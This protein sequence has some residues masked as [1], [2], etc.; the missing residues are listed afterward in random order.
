M[1]NIQQFQFKIFVT[2]TIVGPLI[3]CGGSNSSQDPA[4][5]DPAP[6]SRQEIECVSV[7]GVPTLNDA[8]QPPSSPTGEPKETSQSP[9]IGD[10]QGHCQ[11][12]LIGPASLA[13]ENA[14]RSWSHGE[15]S[16]LPSAP[17]GLSQKVICEQSGRIWN[18]DHCQGDMFPTSNAEPQPI[19]F[20]ARL[21]KDVTFVEEI[22][23][24]VP[25]PEL[26]MMAD[27][28][29]DC[30]I[31]DGLLPGCYDR[32]FSELYQD[33]TR[34]KVDSPQ[35]LNLA[36]VQFLLTHLSINS[37]KHLYYILKVSFVDSADKL[38][39]NTYIVKPKI[40][41]DHSNWK[42][43]ATGLS[44]AIEKK[45]LS[46]ESN[47]QAEILGFLVNDLGMDLVGT[48]SPMD[49]WNEKEF[50]RLYT[51][52]K[53]PRGFYHWSKK[54]SASSISNRGSIIQF[55]NQKIWGHLANTKGVYQDLLLDVALENAKDLEDRSYFI[56]GLRD[57]YANS[58]DNDQKNKLSLAY[59][60]IVPVNNVDEDILKTAKDYVIPGQLKISSLWLGYGLQVLEKFGSRF[61]KSSEF[62][63]L[64]NHY[65]F[66]VRSHLARALKTFTDPLADQ[67]LLSLSVDRYFSVR[68]QALES[69]RSRAIDVKDFDLTCLVRS[70]DYKVRFSLARA[71]K[72]TT[73]SRVGEVLLQ[74]NADTSYSVRDAAL[75]SLRDRD[76]DV[77]D[78][79]LAT[80]INM[81]D[82][83]SRFGLAQALKYVRGQRV[84][85]TLLTLNAD[86]SYSVRD[87]AFDSLKNRGMDVGN[88]NLKPMINMV[89]YNSRIGLARA[90]KHVK[91]QNVAETLL[92]LNADQSYSVRDQ[93]F[94]S[95][96]DRGMDVGNL[97]LKPMINMGDYNSRIGLARALEHVK[98]EKVGEALLMLNADQSY[99]VRDK[100]FDSLRDRGMDVGSIDLKP[101][102]NMED[103]NSRI[104]LARALKHVKG[105]NVAETLLTLNADRSYSVRNEAF[106]SLRDRGM[107]VG[108]INLK[109]MINMEDYNS[110]IGLV[111][112]LK[113]VKGEKVGEALLLLNADLNWTVRDEAFSA[114]QKR[115]LD[116]RDLDV[117]VL[118]NQENRDSRLGLARAL[119]YFRGKN[120]D[121]ALQVLSKDADSSVRSKAS[122]S[123]SRR[124]RS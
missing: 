17:H 92:T 119:E 69:L 29:L 95:L 124:P 120:V 43:V 7:Q 115:T 108:S 100:A 22:R 79:N 109:P 45:T 54:I 37:E 24:K 13:C 49:N 71:L 36:S 3:S 88:L 8:C 27:E 116:I 39:S 72:H 87:E 121:M 111:R 122:E 123:I 23:S 21:V 78:L 66:N 118:I 52:Q 65:D 47:V 59:L 42:S 75:T 48:I 1:I 10:A 35:G 76:L 53:S 12:P 2:L 20:Y 4:S 61:G 85:E 112:A 28:Y 80:M 96:R 91:G 51:L 25:G 101:M 105:H 57:L 86:Q 110:R 104:G 55:F 40:V 33:R 114:I 64:V 46:S 93:A 99:S 56:S 63:G 82:Y 58:S 89:D 68:D 73:G 106:D 81:S 107:D 102:I 34:I 113:H 11:N 5:P 6:E 14:G 41:P 97:N 117:V 18:V 84:A 74:L 26:S 67:A 38:S 62:V 94:D 9:R 60:L 50:E 83:N 19:V 32:K 31:E 90:L 77:G 30:G 44:Q 15:C 70:D 16:S 103:Y 98:G